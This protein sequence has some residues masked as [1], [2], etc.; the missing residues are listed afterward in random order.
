MHFQWP[1]RT[2]VYID[3]NNKPMYNSM[4]I[5]IIYILYPWLRSISWINLQTIVTYIH[6]RT[7]A[8][9]R[10]PLAIVDLFFAYAKPIL[11]NLHPTRTKRTY[12]GRVRHRDPC[13]R[14]HY[15]LCL[16]LPPRDM[17]VDDYLNVFSCF[18]HISSGVVP[19]AR[20]LRVDIK[21]LSVAFVLE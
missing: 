7:W 15:P 17:V 3:A 5:Y 4:N 12:C 1:N 6:T 8:G 9:Y 21:Y 14:L 11:S 18:Y 20:G 10:S 13:Y 19:R 16:G 2:R